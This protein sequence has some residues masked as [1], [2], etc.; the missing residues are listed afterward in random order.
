M[1]KERTRITNRTKGDENINK[2]L[3]LRIAARYSIACESMCAMPQQ[4]WI[5]Y[6]K[7]FAL[8]LYFIREYLVVTFTSDCMVVFANEL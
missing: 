6:S 1:G 5:I 4:S 8:N 7:E 2:T 3:H